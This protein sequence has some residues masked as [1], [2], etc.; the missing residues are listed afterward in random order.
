MNI[1]IS[2]KGIDLTQSIKDIV[3]KKLSKLDK[4]INKD[5]TCNVKIST[6]K[7]LQKIEVTIPMKNN[8]VRA[9]HSSKDLYQSIDLVVDILERQI[10]KYKT[11]IQNKKQANN[12]AIFE[13]FTFTDDSP[14]E[15]TEIKIV[16]TKTFDMKP[17]TPEE[18][19][20]QMELVGHD[21]FV[22]SNAELGKICVVYKR[23]ADSYGLILPN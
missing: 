7:D 13:A 3:E 5:A 23:G 4:F 19:C 9:E 1:N 16:K 12:N 18:A 6:Q 2:G 20:L 10:R 17:M 14:S 15:D 11:K 21:F 8:T 22:F